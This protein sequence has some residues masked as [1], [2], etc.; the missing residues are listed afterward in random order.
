MSMTLQQLR[1]YVRYRVGQRTGRKIVMALEPEPGLT[2]ETTDEVIAFFRGPL[3]RAFTQVLGP[4]TV[5]PATAIA[6]GRDLIGVNFDFCHQSI[7]FEDNPTSLRR[8]VDAGIRLYKCHAANAMRVVD[9][10]RNPKACE[11]LKPFT[12]SIFPHQV[13]GADA[14][15]RRVFFCM[16]LP[17]IFTP[18]GG[19]ELERKGVRE[20]RIHYHVPVFGNFS[21][22]IDTTIEGTWAG[23]A[24]FRSL[25]PEAPLIV[26]CYTWSEQGGAEADRRRWIQEG[27]AREVRTVHE[28]ILLARTPE[29][30][31]RRDAD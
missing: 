6:L 24:A 30:R 7:E 3:D 28:T 9:P 8:L 14:G 27:L 21:S 25:A 17:Y 19:H 11:A 29:D 13:I 10:L 2:Y 1:D 26:E 12:D 4:E 22:D 5:G 16:D 20:I 15:G 23:I 18:E 31:G